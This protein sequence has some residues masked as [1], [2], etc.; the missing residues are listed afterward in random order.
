LLKAGSQPELKLK[1]AG[2]PRQL[3]FGESISF[4]IAEAPAEKDLIVRVRYIPPTGH[5]SGGPTLPEDTAK[6]ITAKQCLACH[7]VDSPSV[8]PDYLN[9]A[10]RYRHDS[11]AADTLQKKLKAGGAGVWGEIPMPPQAALNEEESQKI[12]SAILGLAEGM[13]E[14]RGQAKGSL[15]LPAAPTNAE[16]GGAW[17]ITAQAPNC[18]IAKT[19]INA[20]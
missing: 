16:P 20:K 3:G 9:V 18:T 7:Q 4:T 14:V 1:L 2:N 11:K 15:K 12:I 13:G 5:D 8:G 19:R 6:L 17:E 10:M